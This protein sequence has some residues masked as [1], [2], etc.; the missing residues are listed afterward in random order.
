[1]RTTYK[2][3]VALF[4]G[5]STGYVGAQTVRTQGAKPPPAYIIAEVEADPAKQA[6]PVDATRYAEEAPKSLAAFQARYLVRGGNVQT[7]EGDA[8]KGYIVVIAFD[9]VEQAR[10]WYNS[11]AYEAIKPIRQNTTKSRLLL[12]EGVISP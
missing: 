12:A 3:A 2:V 10:D 11:P 5:I 7:L 1:M 6:N 8:P 4:I 9:S